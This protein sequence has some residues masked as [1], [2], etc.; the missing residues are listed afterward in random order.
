MTICAC[1]A[2][3]STWVGPLPTLGLVLLALCIGAHIFGNAVGTRLREIGAAASR[4]IDEPAA[5]YRPPKA[6][7]ADFAPQSRLAERHA[8]GWPIVI[9][10]FGGI[11]GGGFGGGVWTLL[12]SRGPA[13]PFNIMVGVVAFAVLGGIASFATFGFVQVGASAVRQALSAPPKRS[14]ASDDAS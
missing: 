5:D 11:L 1:L 7:A 9:A 3:A 13:S 4:E 8:L 10:T 14:P 6:S 2:A 12:T